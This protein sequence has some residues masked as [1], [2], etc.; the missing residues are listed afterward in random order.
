MNKGLF[1][2]WAGGAPLNAYVVA[3]DTQVIADGGVGATPT[4]KTAL[5]T[6]INSLDSAG[7]WSRCKRFWV[8]HSG[9]V[10][11][12]R[13]NIKNPSTYRMSI[14]GTSPTFL[15]GTGCKS[16][17][18]TSC[19]NTTV[20]ANDYAGI[21]TDLTSVIYMSDSSNPSSSGFAFGG[22][23]NTDFTLYGLQPKTGAAVMGLTR[24]EAS[25]S[26]IANTTMKG[27]YVDTYDGSNKVTYKDGTKAT[28]AATV[29]AP[30]IAAP[31]GLLAR[32][33]NGGSSFTI[34]SPMAYYAAYYGQWDRVNDSEAATLRTHF[35]TYNTA[36]GIP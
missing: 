21:G 11:D 30:N 15:E 19:F 32:N 28:V 9:G 7:L 8:L 13:R 35:T 2:W 24:F 17:D 29:T 14:V 36:V 6:L 18:A 34:N 10:T 26:S 12:A 3:W 27:F 22:R 4:V 1:N 5:S 16:A 23:T 20:P 25:A 31:M 33:A